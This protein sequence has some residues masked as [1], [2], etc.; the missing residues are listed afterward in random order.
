[1]NPVALIT[2]ASRG[3]GRG[4]ALELA[5]LGHDLVINYAGNTAAAKQTAA[6]ALPRRRHRPTRPSA[7]KSARRT[8]ARSADRPSLID[9]TRTHSGGWM[10]WSTTPALLRTCAPTFWRPPRRAFDRLMAINVKGPY[11]LTQLAA[12]WMIERWQRE[13]GPVPFAPKIITISSI[14]PTP[15]PTNRGDYCVTKAA[16]SRCSRRCSPRAWRSTGSMFTRS[17]RASSP[18]T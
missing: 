16:P 11:F 14:A 7:P 10:C 5:R 1:M 18:P 6:I 12:K 17:A 2:G 15:P 4:I 13:H 9:F 8:S 3:I